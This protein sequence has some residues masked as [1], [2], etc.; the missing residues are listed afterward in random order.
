MAITTKYPILK[1]SKHYVDAQ[2]SLN[3]NHE[4]SLLPS[5]FISTP[6]E[7][8]INSNV[9]DTQ[10]R[11]SLIRL[12]HEMK[13]IKTDHNIR[14]SQTN[15]FI[16]YSDGSL[17][18][19]TDHEQARMG[20]GWLLQDLDHIRFKGNIDNWPSSTRAELSAIWTLILASP[21]NSF[22]TLYTDSQA[23]ID[24]INKVRTFGNRTKFFNINNRTLISN[25]IELENRKN[26]SLNLKKVKAHAGI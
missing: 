10:T 9:S 1:Q 24:G 2:T 7:N 18:K 6:D 8:L 17:T 22:I 11:S 3:Q 4:S 13:I 19:T 14:N 5:I 12:L 25:I 15:P 21:E 26:I 20:F 23:T 16:A